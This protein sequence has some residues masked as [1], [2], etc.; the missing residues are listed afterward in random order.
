[1]DGTDRAAAIQGGRI[2]NIIAAAVTACAIFL[3]V[4]DATNLFAGFLAVVVVFATPAVFDVHLSVLSEPL[5]IMTMILSLLVMTAMRDRWLLLSV[6]AASAVMV[7]YAG[8]SVLVAVVT[9]T[10]LDT[11]F[12][13]RRRVRRTI[14]L[15]VIPVL[16]LGVWI[17]RTAGAPDRHGTPHL[18]V[19]G[20]WGPTLQQ[21]GETMMQWLVP[22]VPDGFGRGVLALLV[23]VAIVVLITATA[24]DTMGVRLRPQGFERVEGLLG[25]ASLLL[26][27]YV[28]VVIG[29]RLTVGGTIP[30]DGRILAPGIALVEIMAVVSA[31]HWWHAY[32]RPV[33]IVASV[34][35]LIWLAASAFTTYEDA[36]DAA[37]EGSDFAATEWRESALLRWVRQDGQAH[38]LYSNWPPAIYFHTNRIARELPD[39]T[40]VKSDLDDF[41]ERL[42]I[43]NGVIVGFNTKSPDVV[44]PDSLAQML[45][46][47]AIIR[48]ND[49]VVWAPRVP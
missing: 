14:G 48:T 5:F 9:W 3:L 10:L 39:S 28:V 29:S 13:W 6:L 23:C 44:S 7:R 34:V 36:A 26:G 21:A 31:T 15:L 40:E 45:S 12:A 16:T 22:G 19:Y 38:T 8:A 11:R 2:V 4:G 1:M 49:G 27:W 42:R 37:T 32:Y 41:A 46:L 24:R 17:T 18:S 33:R 25:A 47:R 20:H 43:T 35:G 30:F